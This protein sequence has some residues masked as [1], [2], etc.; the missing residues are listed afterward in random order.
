MVMIAFVGVATVDEWGKG[1]T[2]I[3]QSGLRVC[4]NCPIKKR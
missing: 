2:S 4:P 1:V 3:L